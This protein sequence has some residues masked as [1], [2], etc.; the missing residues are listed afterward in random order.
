MLKGPALCL[1]LD[2]TPILGR[3]V[4]KN[5]YNLLADSIRQ[6][7]RT[8]ARVQAQDAVRWAEQEGYDRY[9][10]SSIK[11]STEVD[12]SDPEAQRAFLAA[13][14]ADAERLLYQALTSPQ[15]ADRGSWKRPSCCASCCYRTLSV[16]WMGWRCGRA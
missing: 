9:L 13:I 16:G 7:L 10:E 3:G 6:L 5:I 2:T 14:V 11:G 4:V 15:A 12:W 8:L 1:V